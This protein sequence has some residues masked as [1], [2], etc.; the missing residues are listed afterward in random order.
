MILT[1]I[2]LITTVLCLIKNKI[3]SFDEIKLSTFNEP[4][5]VVLTKEKKK[6]GKRSAENKNSRAIGMEKK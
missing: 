4:Q 3:P 5:N 1:E 6:T 2:L